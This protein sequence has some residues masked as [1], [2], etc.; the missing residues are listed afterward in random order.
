MNIN[1]RREFSA[2]MVTNEIVKFSLQGILQ[3]KISVQCP[4]SIS[5][6]KCLVMTRKVIKNLVCI[7]NPWNEKED[8]CHF[9]QLLFCHYHYEYYYFNYDL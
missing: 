5:I 1:I 6:G 7:I 8:L 9:P 4:C 2:V 3:R